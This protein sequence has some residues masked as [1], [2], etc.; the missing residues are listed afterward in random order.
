[1]AEINEYLTVRNFMQERN[2]K[3]STGKCLSK[4]IKFTDI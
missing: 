1:M 4:T 3:F 2:N